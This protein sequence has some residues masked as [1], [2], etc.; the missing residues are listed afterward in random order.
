[1]VEKRDQRK[2]PGIRGVD[3]VTWGN[4]RMGRKAHLGVRVFVY[5]GTEYYKQNAINKMENIIKKENDLTYKGGFLNSKRGSLV[6]TKT[7]LSFITKNKTVFDIPVHDILNVAA[8]K[9]LGNGIDHLVI[10]AKESDKERKIKIEHLAFWSGVA[11]GNM[12]QLREPY[13]KL[14]EKTI[15]DLRLSGR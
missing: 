12:S 4:L 15:D 3:R 11:M 13:F 7:N 9:G 2:N 1:M 8:K 5:L 14:W 6:L 10:L